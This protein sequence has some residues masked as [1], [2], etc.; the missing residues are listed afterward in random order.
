MFVVL[1]LDAL[2]RQYDVCCSVRVMELHPS[3]SDGQVDSI[4]SDIADYGGRFANE[5]GDELYRTYME[6]AKKQK[7]SSDKITATLRHCSIL[8]DSLS[9]GNGYNATQ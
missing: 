2:F 1:I 9:G 7:G 8:C 4:T 5:E 6:G 3:H